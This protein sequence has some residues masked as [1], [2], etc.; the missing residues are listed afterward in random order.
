MEGAWPASPA[1]P[2]AVTRSPEPGKAAAGSAERR[3]SGQLLIGHD[4]KLLR[5]PAATER[6]EWAAA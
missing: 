1:A 3:W 4:G 6:G 2:C 5:R